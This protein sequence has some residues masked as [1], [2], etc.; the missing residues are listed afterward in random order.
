MENARSSIEESKVTRAD[1]LEIMV[2]NDS[3]GKQFF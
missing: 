3:R 2:V 1:A